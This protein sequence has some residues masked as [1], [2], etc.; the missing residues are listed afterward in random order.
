[1]KISAIFLGLLL[2]S[3]SSATLINKRQEQY[4]PLKKQVMALIKSGS[5]ANVI[6]FLEQQPESFFEIM[7]AL[8]DAQFLQA[9]QDIQAGK[10]P[11]L[12]GAAPAQ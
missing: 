6:T 10:T 9:V 11:T 4:G 12:P 1:M 2:A 8:P 5:P 7:N 3:V